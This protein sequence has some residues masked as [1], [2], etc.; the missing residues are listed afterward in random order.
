MENRKFQLSIGGTF[1]FWIQMTPPHRIYLSAVIYQ[2]PSL[3][4]AASMAITVSSPISSSSR[5]A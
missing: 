4:F 1:I 2:F 5:Q 3:Q